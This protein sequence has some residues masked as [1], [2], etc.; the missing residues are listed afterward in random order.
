MQQPEQSPYCTKL[1]FLLMGIWSKD[2]H[3]TR[4]NTLF[5]LR[6]YIL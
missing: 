4:T 1:I 6:I 2:K 5:T 3:K